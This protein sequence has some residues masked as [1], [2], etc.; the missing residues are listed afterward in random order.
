MAHAA[1][2]MGETI[3][4]SGANT[5]IS[6]E[7]SIS[8]VSGV[9]D[10]DNLFEPTQAEK[11]VRKLQQLSISQTVIDD[12][13]AV[14]LNESGN[15]VVGAHIDFTS[16]DTSANVR[17]A[18]SAMMDILF[19]NDPSAV[20]FVTTKADIGIILDSTDSAPNLYAK[21]FNLST[22]RVYAPGQT[23]VIDNIVSNDEGVYCALTQTGHE[24][25]LVKYGR[26]IHFMLLATGDILMTDN[27]IIQTLQQGDI[28]ATS[29][30]TIIYADGLFTEGEQ[31]PQPEP[32]PEPEPEPIIDDEENTDKSGQEESNSLNALPISVDMLLVIIGILVVFLIVILMARNSKQKE[33]I[34]AWSPPP[35]HER[36]RISLHDNQLPRAPDLSNRKP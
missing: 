2:E 29:L 1:K 26:E 20:S 3:K 11:G 15:T 24:M 22:V 6:V 17:V 33:S 7:Q 9:V 34:K 36:R 21:N 25:K 8:D 18:R 23:V 19:G 30:G 28:V 13:S 35:M 27:R 5:T 16:I 4:S 14:S 12:I 10:T 32:E 31:E